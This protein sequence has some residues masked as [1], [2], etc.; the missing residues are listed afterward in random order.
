MPNPRPELDIPSY[1]LLENATSKEVKD[2][3][4]EKKKLLN[5][6]RT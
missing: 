5:N 2:C 4:S 3:E 1:Q 6:N